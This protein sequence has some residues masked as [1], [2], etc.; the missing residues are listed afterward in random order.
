MTVTESDRIVAGPAPDVICGG[1]CMT[2][3]A[4]LRCPAQQKEWRAAPELVT[5]RRFGFRAEA[6]GQRADAVFS[7]G[8]TV[9][10]PRSAGFINAE[11][12]ELLSRAIAGRDLFGASAAAPRCACSGRRATTSRTSGSP[13]RA[14]VVSPRN[15]SPTRPGSPEAVG[16]LFEPFSQPRADAKVWFYNAVTREEVP[17]L[18]DAVTGTPATD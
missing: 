4:P 14:S 6:G 7:G 11:V 8:S 13:G 16:T 3:P 5:R 12:V 9:S 18:D 17:P 15:S 10:A 2:E 1:P